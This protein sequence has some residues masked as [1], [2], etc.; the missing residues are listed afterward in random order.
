M[1]PVKQ[2]HAFVLLAEAMRQIHGAAKG[3]LPGLQ[4]VEGGEELRVGHRTSQIAE[5][6]PR[7]PRQVVVR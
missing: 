2:G 3:K 5:S 6:G 1:K 4:V 7:L